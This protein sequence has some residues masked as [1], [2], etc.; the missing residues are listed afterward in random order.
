MITGYKWISL[1]NTVSCYQ[2]NL[3]KKIIFHKRNSN[4]IPGNEGS[5]FSFLLRMFIF[6][7]KI[8]FWQVL[9]KMEFRES[10][11]YHAYLTWKF[12]TSVLVVYTNRNSN[13]KCNHTAGFL[14][15]YFISI[16]ASSSTF[17]SSFFTEGTTHSIIPS[18]TQNKRLLAEREHAWIRVADC[19]QKT[20]N[21]GRKS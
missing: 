13:I 15:K 8:T 6:C 17:R 21:L 7:H 19:N 2:G 1:Q 16:I 3:K 18:C 9:M 12:T 10:E 5:N 4:N 11:N 20:H 14:R